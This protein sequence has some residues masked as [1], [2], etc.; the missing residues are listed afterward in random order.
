MRI[1]A[2]EIGVVNR[3]DLLFRRPLNMTCCGRSVLPLR[4]I[5]LRRD[6]PEDPRSAGGM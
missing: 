4:R 1:K 6:R 3:F 5:G 2:H